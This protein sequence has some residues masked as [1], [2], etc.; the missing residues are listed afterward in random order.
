MYIVRFMLISIVK[1]LDVYVNSIVCNEPPQTMDVCEH[2]GYNECMNKKFTIVLLEG[3][4][5][6]LVYFRVVYLLY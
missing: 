1:W 4:E 5:N 6:R 3:F 2:C